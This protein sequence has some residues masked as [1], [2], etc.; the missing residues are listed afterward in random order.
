[1]PPEPSKGRGPVLDL[2][3]ARV[4]PPLGDI[5]V[6]MALE[7]TV[8]RED[9]TPLCKR[10]LLADRPLHRLK[11]LLGR[12]ALSPGEGMLL[13]PAPAVHTCFMRFS[14]DAVF[15][16][17]ELRVVGV[18]PGLKPWRWARRPGARAVLELAA[19]EAV[20][21]GVHVGERL[22]LAATPYREGP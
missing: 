22:T 21:H 10:C 2:L 5:E 15:V 9:G 17:R 1:M 6:H 12:A 4:E 19:G 18:E 20:R 16:D 3:G 8:G 14:I 13:R 11:G 7:A